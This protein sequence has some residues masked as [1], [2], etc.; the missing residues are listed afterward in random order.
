M[1]VL[2]ICFLV[3][4]QSSTTT[5]SL[6]ERIEE[7][8]QRQRISER[9]EELAKEKA[10]EAA[11]TAKPPVVVSAEPGKGFTVASGDGNYSMNIIGRIVPRETLV[12]NDGKWT[13]ELNLRTI[14]LTFQGNVLT[15][16]VKYQ[17]QLAIA[18]NDIERDTG[19]A[20]EAVAPSVVLDAWIGYER[21]RDLNFRVGQLYVP[22]DRA[23][24]TRE[25]ALQLVDRQLAV[26]ELSLDRDIGVYLY[27]ADLFGTSFLSYY[28][29]FWGGDG[30]NRVAATRPGFL[31]TARVSV[32]PFGPFDDDIEGDLDRLDKPRLAI[33]GGFAYNTRTDRPRSTLGVPLT[34]GTF[35]YLHAAG[36]LVFKYAGFSLFGEVLFRNNTG[37]DS[38]TGLD[39]KG[40]ALTEWSRSSWGYFAQVAYM[41]TSI[42]EVAVRWGE[43]RTIG[44]TDPKLVTFVAEQGRELGGGLSAYLNGHRFKVQLDY[45]YLFGDEFSEG[46]HQTRLQLNVLM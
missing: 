42:F 1:Y 36:D 17:L 4:A 46:R 10:A 26:N 15:P 21:W 31:Y 13:N 3:V 16:H 43:V 38:K 28:L 19:V 12:E 37:E 2:N 18:G 39:S 23:R 29:G 33:G 20:K 11:K 7:L 35:N 41:L 34:L 6:E 45:F 8:E 27:S 24:T 14:R 9:K 44:E 30:R 32:R 22:F 5:P 25:F 40:A